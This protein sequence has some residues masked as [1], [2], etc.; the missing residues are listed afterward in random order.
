MEIAPGSYFIQ[1]PS[2]GGRHAWVVFE[3]GP[4]SIQ[5]IKYMRGLGEE[6][7]TPEDIQK[8]KRALVVEKGGLNCLLQSL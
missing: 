7:D 4:E 3:P 2:Q 8:L 5:D 1:M 6:D